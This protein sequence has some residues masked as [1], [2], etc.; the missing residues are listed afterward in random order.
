MFL[1]LASAGK[2]P[3]LS[4]ILLFTCNF[5]EFFLQA[6]KNG[7]WLKRRIGHPERN[8]YLFTWRTEVQTQSRFAR[9]QQLRAWWLYMYLDNTQ[10]AKLYYR[11]YLFARWQS[12]DKHS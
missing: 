12:L 10:Y 6:F 1:A 11:K 2:F 7:T 4:D 8:D 9:M 3:L 5:G